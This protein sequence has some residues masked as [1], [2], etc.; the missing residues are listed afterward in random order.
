MSDSESR[1]REECCNL[2]REMDELWYHL[3]KSGDLLKLKAFALFNVQ[4][5]TSAVSCATISYLRSIL[6]LVRGSVLDYEIELLYT[7]T[8]HSVSVVTADP[9]QLTTEVLMWLRPF[10]AYSNTQVCTYMIPI[11]IIRHTTTVV[12]LQIPNSNSNS[13]GAISSLSANNGQNLTSSTSSSTQPRIQPSSSSSTVSHSTVTT[14]KPI[15]NVQSP[16]EFVNQ[17][18]SLSRSDT[19]AKTIFIDKLLID[20]RHECLRKSRPFLIPTNTWLNLPSSS[21]VISY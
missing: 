17:V 12:Y 20:T 7:M 16:T 3:L 4:F 19:L 8:K 5:L 6:E 1:S 18:A 2:L 13:G 10:S 11:K 14:K 9:D 21:Q 15:E